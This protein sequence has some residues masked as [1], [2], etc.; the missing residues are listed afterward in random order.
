MS[1]IGKEIIRLREEKGW[2]QQELAKRSRIKAPVISRIESGK[3]EKPV[4][5]LGFEE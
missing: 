5:W 2:N 3:V 4:Y 1:I